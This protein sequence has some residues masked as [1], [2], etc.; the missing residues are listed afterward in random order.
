M[1]LY[2][3]QS[4]DVKIGFLSADLSGLHPVTY[5]LKSILSNYDSNKI[6]VFLYLNHT[7]TEEDISTKDLKKLVNKSYEILKLTDIEAINLIRNDRL[8][9]NCHPGELPNYRGIDSFKWCLFEKNFKGFSTTIHIVRDKIDGGEILKI[10]N[11]DWK[12]VNWFLADNQLLAKSGENL[13]KYAL[14]LKHKKD[15]KDILK[16]AINQ[17]GTYPL[18][19]KMDII[20]ELKTFYFYIKNKKDMFYK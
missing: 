19:F 13:A 6:E 1:C 2:Q 4:F 10:D 11:Y 3:L 9:I 15:L 14:E 18:Y 7:Q 8:F 17:K 20:K 5:F 12:K 16:T